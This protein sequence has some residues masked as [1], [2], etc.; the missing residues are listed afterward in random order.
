MLADSVLS[1][2]MGPHLSAEQAA[3]VIETANHS[4]VLPKPHEIVQEFSK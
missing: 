1:L 3:Y 4:S 2:P